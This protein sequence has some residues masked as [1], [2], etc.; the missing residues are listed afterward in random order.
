VAVQALAGKADPERGTA[1]KAIEGADADDALLKKADALGA[2]V[3]MIAAASLEGD[4][5]ASGPGFTVVPGDPGAL[6]TP[7]EAASAPL[8]IQ[9]LR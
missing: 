5:P 2:L 8:A 4:K 7:V 3:D 6:L 9:L 1:L